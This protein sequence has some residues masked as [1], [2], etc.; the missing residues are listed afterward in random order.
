MSRRINISNNLSFY[1]DSA[2]A[3]NEHLDDNQKLF[4]FTDW[5][6]YIEA[7][8]HIISRYHPPTYAYRKGLNACHGNRRQYLVKEQKHQKNDEVEDDDNDNEDKKQKPKVLRKFPKSKIRLKHIKFMDEFFNELLQ[9][10]PEQ[11]DDFMTFKPSL[12][13]SKDYFAEILKY[14]PEK[15]NLAP[16]NQSTRSL[17]SFINPENIKIPGVKVKSE[18]AQIAQH[19]HYQQHH[20]PKNFDE[21]QKVYHHQKFVKIRT[22]T[23]EEWFDAI[24]NEKI[25]KQKEADR[26]EK[27]YHESAKEAFD[28]FREKNFKK[29]MKENHED[30]QM[31]VDDNETE[32]T[33]ITP[34]YDVWL[35]FTRPERI[36]TDLFNTLKDDFPDIFNW[37]LN[38]CAFIVSSKPEDVYKQLIAI[39]NCF[40][41]VLKPVDETCMPKFKDLEVY[42]P[43]I[44]S[45]TRNIHK[46]W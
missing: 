31:E 17:F 29:N 2:K 16:P 6:N 20:R 30:T 9:L 15:K 11:A 41:H 42:P 13:P 35:N 12:T 21:K 32:L 4:V 40:T 46:T 34:N 1:I 7:R 28:N 8:S 39:E 10:Y 22:T 37:L 25:E 36:Y 33:L 26:K 44:K 45:L 24:K 38:E 14:F 43:K 27:A 5:A 23:L 18:P 19:F 3:L